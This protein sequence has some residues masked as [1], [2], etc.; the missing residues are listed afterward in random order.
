M[1]LFIERGNERVETQMHEGKQ[2]AKA[3]QCKDEIRLAMEIFR[4][5]L[6]PA[7]DMSVKLLY[8]SLLTGTCA[9]R[10]L[11]TLSD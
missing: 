3:V 8:T 1:Q 10:H 9:Q 2:T 7:Q 5:N 4:G 11:I 6:S